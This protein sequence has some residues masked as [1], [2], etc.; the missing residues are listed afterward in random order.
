MSTVISHSVEEHDS[1]GRIYPGLLINEKPQDKCSPD[2]WETNHNGDDTI[3][4]A[5]YK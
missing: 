4:S 3:I 5:G 2:S 1:Y